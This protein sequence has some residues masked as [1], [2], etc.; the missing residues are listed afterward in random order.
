MIRD[1]KNTN[2][3]TPIV[4]ITGYLKELQAPHYF[5]ALIEKP[6]TTSKLTDVMSRLCQWKAPLPGQTLVSYMQPMP[7]SLRRESVIYD[8][9]PLGSFAMAPGTIPGS[10][11]ED[12][13][14][15]STFGDSESNNADDVGAARKTD[16]WCTTG[17]V[18]EEGEVSQKPPHLL[19]Q[20]SAPARVSGDFGRPT[21]VKRESYEHEIAEAGDDEDEELG[22]MP[23]RSGH[24]YGRQ[25]GSKLGTE[26]MRTNSRGSVVSSSD[27]GAV[28]VGAVS[29]SDIAGMDL[30]LTSHDATVASADE[31][32]GKELRPPEVFDH[33]GGKVREVE[34]ERSHSEALS[35]TPRPRTP[36]LDEATPRAR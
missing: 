24:G 18:E 20:S 22:A 29:S 35:T 19:H 6:P 21:M 16:E 33:P 17:V 1:T 9:H 13:I 27:V 14:G 30:G 34:M 28:S 8:K 4:A 15:S 32:T 26:M 36:A 10:S 31:I 2:S 5:D 12:S 23:D 7:S 25:R 3:Q 11:R